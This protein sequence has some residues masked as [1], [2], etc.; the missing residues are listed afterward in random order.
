MGAV[1]ALALAQGSPAAIYLLGRSSTKI[2]P[3]VD[4]IKETSPSTKATFVQ[5]DT[6]DNASVRAAAS[7]LKSLLASSSDVEIHGLVNS[8]GIGAT[9]EYQVSKDGVERQFAVNHIGHF[10][11]TNLIKDEILKGKGVVLQ[12]SSGGFAMTDSNFDDENFNVSDDSWDW[13]HLFE[14]GWKAKC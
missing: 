9:R 10:L 7:K 11:L 4:K 1:A 5:C 13:L 14:E 6:G 2:Q 12:V 8:A 3:V